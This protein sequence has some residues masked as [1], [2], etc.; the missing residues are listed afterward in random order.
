MARRFPPDV[1]SGS[2]TVFEA[3]VHEARERHDVRLVVG[4]KESCAQFPDD[5]IA[6]D[7][8]RKGA[9]AWASVAFAAAREARSFRPDVVMSNSI[10][11]RV[12]GVPTVTIVHDL[13]FGKP[14]SESRRE[15]VGM[16]AREAFY[17]MQ[18]HGLAAVIAVSAHTRDRLVS[19]GIPRH[20]I[21]VIPN[22]VDVARFAASP[23][24]P[25][26]TVRFVH[27]SRIL[28]G[29]GQHASIDALGRMRPDQRANMRLTMVGTIVDRTYAD[30]L[31]VQAFTLP[32]DFHF[33]VPD[34]APFYAAADIAL[35]PTLMEE[36][37]GFA[38]VDA[39]AAG[40]PVIYY[41]QP[42]VHEATGGI[43]VEVPRD[44]ADAL[45]NAMLCLAADPAER[46][47]LGSQGRAWVQ[48]YRWE[49]V[50]QAYE[51]VLQ[52]ASRQ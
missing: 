36:G 33:D 20:R 22:G 18:A 12:P 40:L 42:A 15:S 13:N 41:A 16:R 49:D 32:V 2:E 30:Q 8:R 11:V 17:R 14:G 50:W 35:F 51:R 28:P 4:Y 23:R 37:F 27:V 25:D 48:R 31:R 19:I 38:A 1:R 26:G 43:G 10:E 52:D 47:R 34:V 45:R 29:K 46:A 9:R 5:A 44:D 39:M 7:L 3:L 6:V 21:H 24:V